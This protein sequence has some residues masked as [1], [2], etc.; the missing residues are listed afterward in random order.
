MTTTKFD[1]ETIEKTVTQKVLVKKSDLITKKAQLQAA[2]DEIDADL[3]I[4][5][6]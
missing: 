3:A 2:I 5:S 1:S 4:L 6:E